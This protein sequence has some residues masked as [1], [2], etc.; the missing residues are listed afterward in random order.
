MQDSIY[1][2]HAMSMKKKAND[3]LR[4]VPDISIK[5]ASDEQSEIDDSTS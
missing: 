1:R 3:M 4:N 5:N 2:K